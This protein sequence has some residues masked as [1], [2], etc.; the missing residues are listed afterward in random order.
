MLSAR[1]FDD[2][3]VLC[4]GER[5]MTPKLDLYRWSATKIVGVDQ[6]VPCDCRRQVES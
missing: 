4:H 2:R 6:R 5:V 3:R 1:R